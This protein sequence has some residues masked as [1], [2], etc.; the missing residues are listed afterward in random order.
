MN[1]INSASQLTH[2]ELKKL[3]TH[4]CNLQEAGKL[5][6]ALLVYDRLRAI[7]P[8]SPLLH[9]N[10]GLAFFDLENY[11]KAE[12]HYEKAVASAPED[13]DIHYN[14]GLNFRR[15]LRF[16][17]A[18]ISFGKAYKSGDT[19]VDTLYNLALCHQDLEDYPEA[20]RIY[21]IIL[22]QKP[23]HQSSLNNFA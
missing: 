12:S 16:T 6:D 15:L 7:I 3:F 2:E 5:N 11:S 23:T 13:P 18:A 21:K 14:R 17:D 19:N 9:F 10:C 22:S 4:A 8:G 1:K 20:G